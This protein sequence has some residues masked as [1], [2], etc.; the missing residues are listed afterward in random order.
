MANN[1]EQI[2]N[3]N[4]AGADQSALASQDDVITSD[5]LDPSNN[6]IKL[7][8]D[9]TFVP[10][11]SEKLA[12]ENQK[13]IK[14]SIDK[15]AEERRTQKE[16]DLSDIE[17]LMI[18]SG[19]I[20]GQQ[21]QF[22][23]DAGVGK[24]RDQ[25]DSFQ[26][27]IDLESRALTK[28]IR[29]I[30]SDPNLTQNLAFKRASAAEIRSA[31]FIAD[32]SIAKKV[33][34]SDLDGAIATA[35]AKVN[36]LLKPVET[37]LNAKKFTLE[38]NKDFFN[39]ADKKKLQS[40]INREE[41][42]LKRETT[43]LENLE[44]LKIK[45]SSLAKLNNAPISV[46]NDIHAAEDEASVLNASGSYG[47]DKLAQLNIRL[48]QAQIKTEQAK[49]GNEPGSKRKI[50]T[51][52]EK[53]YWQ[54]ADGTISIIDIPK[55]ISPTNIQKTRDKIALVQKAAADARDLSHASGRSGLRQAGER[56]FVGETD[57]TNYEV[58]TNTLKTNVLSLLTDPGIKKF[59]GPQ[60]TEVDVELM[61]AAG[62]TLNPDKQSPEAALF[63]IQ[64]LDDLFVRII[65]AVDE[66]VAQRE[67]AFWLETEG[68]LSESNY[69]AYATD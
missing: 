60:M 17:S 37:E 48:K 15:L 42:K 67:A 53:N 57:F 5:N 40:I 25:I 63:E 28:S 18:E 3:E 27:R 12:E 39:E 68:I 65:D 47:V 59:F 44:E 58:V 38:Q 56:L 54:N 26:D 22:E 61:T 34:Q 10:D 46:I 21:A 24:F 69:G 31:S 14:S 35:K 16:S 2:N 23:K 7:P 64:R 55:D 43:K 52:G 51:V 30:Q 62:T 11:F 29:S 6:G 32:L 13:D 19:V 1:N 45:Q 8:V 4:L 33:M 49:G 36:A 20:E 50:V 9:E 66:G 41:T